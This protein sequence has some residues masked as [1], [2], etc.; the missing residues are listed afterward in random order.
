MSGHAISVT[1]RWVAI[2][3]TVVAAL[4]WGVL[5]V[6]SPSAA[7]VQDAQRQEIG[8]LQ[9]EQKRL[10]A[11]A[12]EQRATSAELSEL[13]T[14]LAATR[15]DLARAKEAY[16]LAQNALVGKKAEFSS[17]QASIASAQAELGA[18]EQKLALAREQL[19]EKTGTVK[20]SAVKTSAVKT[21]KAERHTKR[22]TARKKKR[23]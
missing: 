5:F 21:R 19:A 16:D 8:R 12:K 4:G 11:V 23:G 22:A 15:D 3:M 9:Q 7:S 10:D 1:Y 18:L 14:R 20:A 13:V 2:I 17:T 6:M